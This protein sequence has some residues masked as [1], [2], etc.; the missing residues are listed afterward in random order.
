MATEL[1]Q[2]FA[3]MAKLDPSKVQ[4]LDAVIVFELSGE[5]GGEWTL[6][7][8]DGQVKVGEGAADSP[9]MTL[10][11]GKEDFIAM[12]QGELN[13]TSAF[14]QGKIKISGDMSL[15]MRLQSILT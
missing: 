10:S 13:A 12:T 9:S 14:M 3:N 6:T 4:G 15:A 5:G 1:E 8:K 11:M 2:V 7:V